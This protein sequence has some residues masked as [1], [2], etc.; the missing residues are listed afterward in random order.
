MLILHSLLTVSFFYSFVHTY[1]IH[2]FKKIL[3]KQKIHKYNKSTISLS[4]KFKSNN[5]LGKNWLSEERVKKLWHKP[6]PH[7]D[8]TGT[9]VSGLS[10][11][12]YCVDAYQFVHHSWWE[13]HQDGSDSD[14]SQTQQILLLELCNARW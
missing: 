8:K 14:V 6:V 10:Q 4:T 9:K 12:T 1:F 11:K 7:E 5:I 13:G 3:K 2:S